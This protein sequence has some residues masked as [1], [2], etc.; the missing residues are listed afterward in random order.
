[1][2]DVEYKYAPG[3][4]PAGTPDR[5]DKGQF[6]GSCNVTACQLP[7]SATWY[8]HGTQRYYCVACATVLNQD[9]FNAADAQRLFGHSLC[10]EGE[11]HGR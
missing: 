5:K 7:D 2:F 11:H 6:G 9:P 1:M 4:H 8:N 3:N 10:T